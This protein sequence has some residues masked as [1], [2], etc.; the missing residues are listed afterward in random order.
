MK[1]LFVSIFSFTSIA[2]VFGQ[3]AISKIPA[4]PQLSMDDE[5]AHSLENYSSI[6]ILLPLFAIALVV[7]M[8]IQIT[9]YVLDYRLKNKII[10]RGISE[11][12]ASSLLEK[13]VTDKKEDSIKWAFLL[14]GLG[15][16]LT[17][18]YQT[19]PLDIHSLAIMAF[20]L[21]LSYLAYY[22]YLRK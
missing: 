19:M 17:V 16:G 4:P 20:S 9:R 15:G 2:I 1:K 6:E 5:I 8:A 21:G 18:A 3:D 11:Q 14:L 22:L 13:S 10:D 12:I 7:T